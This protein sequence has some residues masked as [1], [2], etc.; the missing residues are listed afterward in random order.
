[1]G[2]IKQKVSAFGFSDNPFVS[3]RCIHNFS[4]TFSKAM[5]L[6]KSFMPVPY[7]PL[8]DTLT[9]LYQTNHQ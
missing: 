5:G 4:P 1:M 6:F 3:Q 2:N 7:Y 8:R 9:A